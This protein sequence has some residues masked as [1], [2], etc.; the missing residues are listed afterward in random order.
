[1]VSLTIVA[2]LFLGGLSLPVVYCIFWLVALLFIATSTVDKVYRER[3]RFTWDLVRLT[4]YTA[5]ELLLSLWAASL[6]QLNRT[7]LMWIYRLLHGFTVVG[8]MV[9]AVLF[10]EVPADEWLLLL[11]T[12]TLLIVMQPY[13]EMYFCGMVGLVIA[14]HLQDRG[15]AQGLAVGAVLLYWLT[16]V[17]GGMILLYSAGMNLT[18]EQ[19]NGLFVLPL[20]VPVLLGYLAQRV[21]EL[22]LI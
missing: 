1:M 20:L 3:E 13:T 19:L 21:A 8:L 17:V 16:Y 22:R 2:F 10:A 9:F 11:F 15:S 6:W 5:R 7:W 12:G 4:P 18:A 14:N